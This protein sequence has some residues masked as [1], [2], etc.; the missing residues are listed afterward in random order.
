MCV[1]VTCVGRGSDGAITHLGGSEDDG[2]M[3]WGLT[4]AE[5]IQRIESN[6]WSFFVARPA[7]D[8]VP[9]LVRTIGGAKAL[10][11]ARDDTQTNNLDQLPVCNPPL[12]GTD[13]QFPLSIPGPRQPALVEVV[14]PKAGGGPT[15]V[16]AD[17]QGVYRPSG[18]TAA[19][20][21]KRLRLTCNIPFP[22]LLEVYVERDPTRGDY[23]EA[24][25]KLTKVDSTLPAQVRAQEDQGRGWYDW[26]LSIP[27]ATYPRRFTPAIV[28]LG[29]PQGFQGGSGITI[30]VRNVSYNRYCAGPSVPLSIVLARTTYAPPYTYPPVASGGGTGTKPPAREYK[31]GAFVAWSPAVRNIG[32]STTKGGKRLEVKSAAE[33]ATAGWPQYG[34]YTSSD[35]KSLC[36]PVGFAVLTGT[37]GQGGGIGFSDSGELGVALAIRQPNVTGYAGDI[38]FRFA[39]LGAPASAPIDVEGFVTKSNATVTPRILLD[40]AEQ[41][42]LVVDA[43]RFGGTPAGR[44]RLLDLGRGGAALRELEFDGVTISATVAKKADGSFEAVI[45]TDA[46]QTKVPLPKA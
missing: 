11:T 42:A 39:K 15:V 40:A 6:E 13:P 25:H 35:G 18:W 3:R 19:R 27:D 8:P 37:G 38:L 4:R 22:A 46:G 41:V 36:Q 29:I 30:F 33:L 24:T 12:A 17:A 34:I 26:I 7:A 9:V 1:K 14:G 32:Q 45:T 21:L 5:A 43:N 31:P 10:T 28:V 23:V 20:P 16:T 44:A 2:S